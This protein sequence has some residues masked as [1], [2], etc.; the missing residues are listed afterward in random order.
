MS[1]VHGGRAA[2]ILVSRSQEAVTSQPIYIINQLLCTQL[3]VK[4]QLGKAIAAFTR[5]ILRSKLPNG[6]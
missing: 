1:T 4:T 6:F 5:A 2:L 3:E